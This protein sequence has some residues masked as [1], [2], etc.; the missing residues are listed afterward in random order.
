MLCL[1][2]SGRR[3]KS[4][5]PVGQAAFEAT[6]SLSLMPSVKLG[7]IKYLQIRRWFQLWSSQWYTVNC[8]GTKT[9]R[10]MLRS[11]IILCCIASQRN[12]PLIAPFIASFSVLDGIYVWTADFEILL[13]VRISFDWLSKGI[14]QNEKVAFKKYRSFQMHVQRLHV[15]VEQVA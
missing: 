8:K 12:V 5:R 4:I 3:H 2:E 1:S 10:R 7:S 15:I 13:C 6:G 9:A 11:Q 14:R